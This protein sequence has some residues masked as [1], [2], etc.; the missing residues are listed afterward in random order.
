MSQDALGQQLRNILDAISADA[1]VQAEH[2]AKLEGDGCRIVDG[3]QTSSYD[4]GGACGYEGHDWRTGE[5]LFSGHG[6]L[7]EYDAA[8]DE[9]QQRDGRPWCHIDRVS[10]AATGG[11]RDDWHVVEPIRVPE[12]PES[13]V[14]VLSEWA[15]SSATVQELADLTGLRAASVEVL[16]RER[17]AD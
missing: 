16:R 4:D 9:A 12:I 1:A 14:Q 5:V 6:T 2:I 10:S 8:L 11:A 17:G 7:E 3:G 15:E 13:L